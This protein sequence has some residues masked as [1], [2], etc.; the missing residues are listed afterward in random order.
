MIAGNAHPVIVPSRNESTT[1][2]VWGLDPVQLHDRFWAH[3]GVQVVRPGEA[4]EISDKA[5][6]YLLTDEKV[7]ATFESGKQ[8]ETLYWSSPDLVYVRVH[9]SRERGYRERVVT[10]DADQ[11]VR[12]DRIYEKS[13]PRLMRAAFTPS[14]E[15]AAAW[16]AT[17]DGRT[18]WPELRMRVPRA[19]RSTMIV[20][21]TMY[22][23]FNG[24]D[25][26]RLVRDLM[27]L[28]G[29]PGAVIPRAQQV[30]AG[31]VWADR[32]VKIDP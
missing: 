21:G 28:W 8:L 26:A 31:E 17:V 24:P 20:H 4:E 6:L 19:R 23:R 2:T 27:R 22:G 25:L 10:D 1:P 9:D 18:G 7:L 5:Q 16:R 14:R 12:F 3:R 11:F 15:I 32:D 13:V 30:G 29:G